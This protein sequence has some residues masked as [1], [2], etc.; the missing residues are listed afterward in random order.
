M[1]RKRLSDLLREEGQK[2][3]EKPASGKTAPTKQPAKPV[4]EDPAIPVTAEVIAHQAEQI[5]EFVAELR[6]AAAPSAPI[7][8]ATIAQLEATIAEL[9][10]TIVSLN[11]QLETKQ[12]AALQ[13][14]TDLQELIA[15]LEAKLDHQDELMQELKAE[16]KQAKQ[17]AEQLQAELEDAKQM[18]LQLSQAN[19]KPATTHRPV[20]ES[21][22]A[23]EPELETRKQEL[24]IPGQT[25]PAASQPKAPEPKANPVKQHQVVLRKLLDHPTQPGSLPPM[26]SEPQTAAPSMKLSETDVGWMD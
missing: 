26:P 11:T 5:S 4:E 3:D 13:K 21:S 8:T 17:T 7:D 15:N 6:D 16:A 2:P 22:R 23:A 20:L 14:E 10:G 19:T 24:I 1:A 9:E 18:I 12:Q 25:K